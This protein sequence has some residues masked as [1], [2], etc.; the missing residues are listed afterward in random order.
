MVQSM[1]YTMVV[2]FKIGLRLK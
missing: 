1:N 2:I